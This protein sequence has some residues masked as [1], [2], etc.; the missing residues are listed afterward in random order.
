MIH[1]SAVPF[2]LVLLVVGPFAARSKC[3]PSEPSEP[4]SFPSGTSNVTSDIAVRTSQRRERWCGICHKRECPFSCA[5]LQRA[6]NNFPWQSFVFYL[7]GASAC[8]NTLAW[9]LLHKKV[10]RALVGVGGI[11]V[12]CR[13]RR[14]NTPRQTNAMSRN[15]LWYY[16]LSNLFLAAI[17][18]LKF[19]F[20]F[21]M[22]SFCIIE[23]VS[24]FEWK[25]PSRSGD[26]RIDNAHALQLWSENSTIIITTDQYPYVKDVEKESRQYVPRASRQPPLISF[27]LTADGVTQTSQH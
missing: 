11:S 14:R 6:N 23:Y 3:L 21:I 4:L 19:L 15:N 9:L 10:I 17:F 1:G 22:L 27:K 16:T 24:Q 7:W 5:A 26:L 13:R 18:S 8:M 12:C 2:C 25:I 20:V